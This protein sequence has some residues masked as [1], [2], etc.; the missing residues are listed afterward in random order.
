VLLLDLPLQV[1][2]LHATYLAVCQLA[3]KLLTV[4]LHLAQPECQELQQQQQQTAAAAAYSREATIIH[5]SVAST[6][7]HVLQSQLC[8]CGLPVRKHHMPQQ[9]RIANTW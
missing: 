7:P 3:L 2:G 8:S 9:S 4:P 6:Y 5:T 1:A